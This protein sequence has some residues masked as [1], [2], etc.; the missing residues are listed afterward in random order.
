[1]VIDIL[2]TWVEVIIRVKWIVVVSHLTL[3]MSS[4]QIVEM[5]VTTTDNSPSQVYTYLDD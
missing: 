2:I 3:I 4:A 5:S 1:M